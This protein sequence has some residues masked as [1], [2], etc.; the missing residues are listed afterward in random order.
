MKHMT[1]SLAGRTILLSG[2]T[3]TAGEVV[4][5]TALGLGAQVVVAGHDPAKL[6]ALAGTLPD[7]RTASADLTDEGDVRR[8]AE[9]LHETL[10][11]VDGVLHLVGGWRGGGGLAGQT[12]D[13]FRFLER[14]LTAL[15]HVSRAFD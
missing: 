13:D 3:S 4:A 2:G 6:D 14:S 9:E 10:G 11:R 12:D 1:T 8:L 5:R 15:R 7:L